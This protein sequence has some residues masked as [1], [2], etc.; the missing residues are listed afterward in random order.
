MDRRKFILC[1]GLC[2]IVTTLSHKKVY[3]GEIFYSPSTG[4]IFMVTDTGK[5][6]VLG[7]RKIKLTLG[8]REFT[9]MDKGEE[10]VYIGAVES[11]NKIE[12]DKLRL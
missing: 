1:L 7:N 3:R 2:G 9:V 8:N 6:V 11:S 4:D 5:K 12:L 10:D